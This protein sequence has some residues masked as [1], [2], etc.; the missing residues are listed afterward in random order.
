[1]ETWFEFCHRWA[2]C[3]QFLWGNKRTGQVSVRIN[4]KIE[5]KRRSRWLRYLPF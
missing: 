5:L 3:G 2:D 4:G 1:M